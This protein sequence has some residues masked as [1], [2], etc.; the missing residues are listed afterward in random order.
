M[1]IAIRIA[2]IHADGKMFIFRKFK[3]YI[4]SSIGS[5][6]VPVDGLADENMISFK[7]L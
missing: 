3:G 2:K 1:S 4:H 7:L 5:R 6:S